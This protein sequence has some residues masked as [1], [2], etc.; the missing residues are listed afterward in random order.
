MG[1]PVMLDPHYASL[2]LVRLPG[3][4]RTWFGR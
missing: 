1:R 3:M 2:A 4:L